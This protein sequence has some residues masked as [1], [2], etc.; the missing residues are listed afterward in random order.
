MKLRDRDRRA[1]VT[2]VLAVVALV[3]YLALSG[4]ET[5]A[6]VVAG[7]GSIPLAEKRLARLRQVVA[8]VPMKESELKVISHELAT[9]EKG[10]IIAD[11]AAQA[12]AQLQQSIRR[13]AKTE[14]IDVRG[15]EFLPPQPLGDDYGEVAAAVIFECQIEQLVNLLADLTKEPELLATREIYISSSNSKD[16]KIGVRVLVSGVIPRKLVPV[17]KGITSF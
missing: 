6:T 2:G 1:L 17:K 4:P 15:G 3:I 12:Q 13:V 7:G 10:I 16:K 5:S 14:G 11:T 9:R 8:T